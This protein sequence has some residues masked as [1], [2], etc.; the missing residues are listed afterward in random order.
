MCILCGSGY[1]VGNFKMPHFVPEF[2]LAYA[3]MH[4]TVDY[5]ITVRRLRIPV[6]NR[7]VSASIENQVTRQV[8]Y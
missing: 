3:Q 1:V 6:L 5:L 4:I 2:F 8:N 7:G